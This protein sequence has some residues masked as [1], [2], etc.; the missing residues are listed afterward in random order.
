MN[1]KPHQNVSRPSDGCDAQ[2]WHL[3]LRAETVR[4]PAKKGQ[5]L[6]GRGYSRQREF[7]IKNAH[8]NAQEHQMPVPAC[9][10][11]SK[12][13]HNLYIYRYGLPET[14]TAFGRCRLNEQL[15]FPETAELVGR[16]FPRRPIPHCEMK[17]VQAPRLF[18]DELYLHGLFFQL[19]DNTGELFPCGH[20]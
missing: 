19:P 18:P 8:A 15:D 7:P 20:A 1:L 3:S 4:D 2:I 5:R 10:V 14:P 17:A 9:H 6:Y 12:G 16:V 13:R 11:K